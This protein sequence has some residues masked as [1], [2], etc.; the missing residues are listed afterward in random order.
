MRRELPGP[1]KCLGMQEKNV[2][3][4]AGKWKVMVLGGEEGMECEVCKTGFV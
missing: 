2:Q 1:T 4:N 3:V